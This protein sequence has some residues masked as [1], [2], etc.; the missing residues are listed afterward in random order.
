MSLR[1][2]AIMVI[3]TLIASL[4]LPCSVPVD[5]EYMSLYAIKLTEADPL[6]F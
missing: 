4:F 2:G 5:R 3:A 6:A 1:I